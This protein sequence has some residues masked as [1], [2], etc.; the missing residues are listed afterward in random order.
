MDEKTVIEGRKTFFI[1]PDSTFLPDSYLEDY[2][3]RGYETYIINDFRFCPVDEQVNIIINTFP[4]SILFFSI[5][6]DVGVDWP[7]YIKYLQQEVHESALIGVLYSKLRTEEERR[8]L[9]KYYLFDVGIQCGCIALEYQRMKNFALIDR[10]MYANQASGRRKNVRAICDITS[11]ANFDFQKTVINGHVSD[12][13]MSHFS[14]IPDPTRTFPEIPLYTRI[15]GIFVS[16]NGM[17][18]RTAANLVMQRELSNG[19]T[20]YVFLFLKPNGQPGL[21]EDL[22]PRVS[23]K[24][25]TTITDGVKKI[26]REKVDAW[27]KNNNGV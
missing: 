3:A 1:A 2:M 6:S 15:N 8:A 18:F 26:F 16:F 22:A 17:H 12:I 23:T 20:I 19:K 5:E 13:S 11:K 7:R 9:E 4:D 10:V 24:I 27:V 14:F 21:E 25:Y